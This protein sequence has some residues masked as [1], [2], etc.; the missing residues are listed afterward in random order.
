MS[1]ANGKVKT[2]GLVGG[3]VIGSAWAARLL[4]NNIDVNLYDPAPGIGKRIDQVLDHALRACRSMTSAPVRVR[5]RLCLVDSIEAAVSG[6]D[7]VQESG[8]ERIKVKKVLMQEICKHTGAAVIVASSSSG[9]L[10]GEMQEGVEHPE[11]VIVGHPFNPVYLMPL[12]EIVAGNATSRRVVDR[13][14]AFYAGIGMHPLVVRK[15]VE[16]F[17]ADRL[18]EA[19]WREALHLL[20]EDVATCDELDQAIAYGPGIRWAFM[21]PFETFRIA[22]GEGGIRHFMSQFGASLKWPWARFDGPELTDQL[23]DKISAQSDQQAEGRSI[24][25]LERKRDDCIVAILRAL[26]ANDYAAGKALTRYQ[27]SLLRL[28]REDA[29]QTNGDAVHATTLEGAD[30]GT[31]ATGHGRV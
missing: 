27:E 5:G 28:S 10:P 7:F 8:P 14:R 20:N 21:G 26:Q 19:L 22:G 31:P 29:L 17:I 30:N 13:A 25:E 11:R 4:I 15:E 2:V 3:G 18:M 9:L 16:A 23:L 6:T 12:V 24:A 1:E